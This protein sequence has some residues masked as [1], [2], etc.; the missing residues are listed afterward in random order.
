MDTLET[1]ISMMKPGCYRASVD[2]KEASYMVLI[3]LSP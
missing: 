1:A 3:D 2:L